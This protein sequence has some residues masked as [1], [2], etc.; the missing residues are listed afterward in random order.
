MSKSS[1]IT[2]LRADALAYKAYLVS[3]AEAEDTAE[4]AR[5]EQWRI[6][7]NLAADAEKTCSKDIADLQYT[8]SVKQI[9]WA[10]SLQLEHAKKYEDIALPILTEYYA[11]LASPGGGYSAVAAL[12]ES[13]LL[14]DSFNLLKND[15]DFYENIVASSETIEKVELQYRSVRDSAL[16]TYWK[17]EIA[18]A[19]ARIAAEQTR[20]NAERTLTQTTSQNLYGSY[21]TSLIAACGEMANDFAGDY[22]AS[23]V[24]AIQTAFNAQAAADSN[25]ESSL[26]SKAV[27]YATASLGLETTLVSSYIEAFYDYFA[28]RRSSTA[29]ALNRAKGSDQ[30]EIDA[31]IA[32]Y[33]AVESANCAQ[34]V[35]VVA[36]N[37][38]A[39][40][41][42]L[43]LLTA[44]GEYVVGA[45]WNVDNPDYDAYS[46][47]YMNYY[48][49]DLPTTQTA[50]PS[51]GVWSNN[52]PA[53][54]AQVPIE[55]MDNAVLY[56]APTLWNAFASL[57][58]SVVSMETKNAELQLDAAVANAASV[59]VSAYA[60][61]YDAETRA[62]LNDAE[63]QF[64][65]DIDAETA[66]DD[67]LWSAQGTAFTG[68]LTA[69]RNADT[70]SDLLSYVSSSVGASISYALS[71]ANAYGDFQ[72]AN[73][74]N[75]LAGTT[76]FNP[77]RGAYQADVA[78]A[79]QTK[80]LR[81]QYYSASG[82]AISGYYATVNSA[83][84]TYN[85]AA[86]NAVLSA[87]Q[88]Y[89][90]A[91]RT[92][93]QNALDAYF[94]YVLA[95]FS[96][97]KNLA[98]AY[99][100]A[101]VAEVTANY[102]HE[103]QLASARAAAYEEAVD[104]L[105]SD[106]AAAD[107]KKFE[108][109]STLQENFASAQSSANAADAALDSFNESA[110]AAFQ[111]QTAAAA[112]TA[113]A[114]AD[115]AYQNSWRSAWNDAFLEMLAETADLSSAYD[116]IGALTKTALET[117]D[118]AYR[119]AAFGAWEDFLDEAF[120]NNQI[121]AHQQ[122]RIDRGGTVANDVFENPTFDYEVCLAAGTQILMAD[123]STKPIETIRPGDMVLAADHLNPE[124]QPQAGEVVRFFDNGEKDV[125]KLL[126]DNSAQNEEAEEIV[127]TPEHPFYAAAAEGALP[128]HAG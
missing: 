72:I 71:L 109:L 61:G 9:H 2:F 53:Q 115:A 88:S 63:T 15:V 116:S 38:D 20:R 95:D 77:R 74:Q 107:L 4:K 89:F 80:S 68:E 99:L 92:F 48:S 12:I 22:Y 18:A 13:S 26:I 83:I 103:A 85:A 86:L 65:A 111:A 19:A 127:C 114:E 36:S 81:N 17:A 56:H 7:G 3:Q 87:E 69:I 30:A 10:K 31:R 25:Y 59:Y 100:T 104:A 64:H 58:A 78:W 23:A 60:N 126:F 27:N 121:Y 66:L 84:A 33:Q 32:Y 82:S 40:R 51:F 46:Y 14:S 47:S 34:N 76:L 118:L 39:S 94:D 24:S 113:K 5:A 16:G 50:T 45:A 37:A 6:F 105:L 73:R 49:T 119:A 54:F 98:L 124:S 110:L 101:S 91:E 75:K 1:V 106:L 120:E 90:N 97:S 67:D 42:K 62:A 55:S 108:T 29:A 28:A 43:Q 21:F 96:A 44:W 79:Q 52:V 102:A 70:T 41:R 57:N 11:Y 123:G 128:Q 122:E 93:S 112:E 35:A 125:V 117:A 8:E